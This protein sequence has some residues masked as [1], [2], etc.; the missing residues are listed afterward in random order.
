VVPPSTGKIIEVEY[1]EVSDPPYVVAISNV[2][3]R[4][5]VAVVT[6]PLVASQSLPSLLKLA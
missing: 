5:V 3:V 1:H 4:S 2:Q 6:T